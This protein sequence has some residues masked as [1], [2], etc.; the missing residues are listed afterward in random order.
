MHGSEEVN[1]HGVQSAYLNVEVTCEYQGPL[2]H[3]LVK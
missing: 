1:I 3:Q 2:N